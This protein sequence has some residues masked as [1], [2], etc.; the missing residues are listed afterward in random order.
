MKTI[1]NPVHVR[2]T[3]YAR[4][5]KR[6]A[7]KSFQSFKD[8][9]IRI[10]KAHQMYLKDFKSKL[11]HQ[12]KKI[13]SQMDVAP[14]QAIS[15]WDRMGWMDQMDPTSKASPSRAPCSA[16]NYI[17]QTTF[18]QICTSLVCVLS[19]NFW[20]YSCRWTN[21]SE[22][23]E[24]SNESVE[25]CVRSRR[26]ADQEDAWA[27]EEIRLRVLWQEIWH[28]VCSQPPREVGSWNSSRWLF[29]CLG[30]VCSI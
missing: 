23:C 4:I 24:G 8:T 10:I 1:L 18:K 29:W 26:D 14:P 30:L 27:T 7:S 20:L 21:S 9:S 16:K 19:R 12:K 11:I 25:N 5:L 28:Q 6:P 2:K 3:M 15:V 17:I 22:G 13:P